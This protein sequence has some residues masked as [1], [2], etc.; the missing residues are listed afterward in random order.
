MRFDNV[1]VEIT[2]LSE[3]G[4]KTDPTHYCYQTKTIHIR[5]DYRAHMC[6]NDA[7]SHHWL[8]YE[9]AHHL[10][11]EVLGMHYVQANSF[12]YPD[13]PIERFAF[14]YQFYYLM[15]QKAC[16]TLNDVFDRDPF[17]RH[18]RIYRETLDYYWN[19]ANFIVREFREKMP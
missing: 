12:S 14:A 10:V 1:K 7:L 6:K 2:S 15:S 16:Q 19:N 17:M 8:Y 18:K 3:W 4:R 9:F 11:S 13:N 5:E